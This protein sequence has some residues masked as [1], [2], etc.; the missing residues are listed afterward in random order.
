MKALNRRAQAYEK[1]GDNYKSL[2]DYTA[3]CIME[4][5]KVESTIQSTERLL[6]LVAAERVATVMEAKKD[7]RELP[8]GVFITAYLDSFRK[9]YSTENLVDNSPGDAL[10]KQA[11]DELNSKNFDASMKHVQEALLAGVSQENEATARNLLGTYK[12]LIG[13]VDV[14]IEELNKSLELDPSNINSMIKLAGCQ[15]EKGN[16]EST[17]DH[18]EKQVFHGDEG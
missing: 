8:S 9:G 7:Q 4:E 3:M 1:G 15:M 18:F 17:M 16:V 13:E 11:I 6:K 10:L 12:F 2:V 14:A 5:F